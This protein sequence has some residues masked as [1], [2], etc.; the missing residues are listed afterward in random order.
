MAFQIGYPEKWRDYSSVSVDKADA[1]GNDRCLGRHEHNRA[2]N[3][4][5]RQVDPAD[6]GHAPHQVNAYYDPT[7]NTF[8]LLA[9]ILHK[10]FFDVMADN[11]G[12]IGFIIGHEIGHA[13]DDQGSIFD[14]NGNL[15]NWWTEEDKAAYNKL[16]QALIDQANAYEILPGTYLNGE[17][18]IGEI[19]GDL[20]GAQIAL[21][22]YRK[23]LNAEGQDMMKAE[24]K[25][26]AQLARTWRSNWREEFIRIIL[27]SDPHPPSEF[28]ANGIVKQFDAVYDAFGVKPGDKMYLPPDQR[29]LLW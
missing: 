23:A 22:A 6:W 13:F 1:V 26:F 15:N 12:G 21:A 28:R 4:I 9:G 3:K 24:Q 18:E 10:P 14:G 27:Q 11:Y 5:G 8:V 2:M 19:M 29:V 25:F 7:K 16:K 17:L 20:S